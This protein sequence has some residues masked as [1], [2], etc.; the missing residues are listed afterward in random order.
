MPLLEFA[1]AVSQV[2]SVP[3]SLTRQVGNVSAQFPLPQNFIVRTF[4]VS[5]KLTIQFVRDAL[6][7]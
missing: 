2:T 3:L 5:C 6:C 4:G 7:K 1:M